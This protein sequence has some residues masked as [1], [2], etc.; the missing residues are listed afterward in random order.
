MIKTIQTRPAI[1]FVVLMGVVSLFADV[2]YE[3]ARSITG[4]YLAVLGA[5]AAVV[6]VV[7]GAGELIGY[8]FRLISG[9]ISDRTGRYWFVTILGY[10][11]NLLAV[12][13]LALT[14]NW[15]LAAILIMSER[16]GKA[17]RTPARD[18]MLSHAV[19]EMGSGWGFGLHEAMDQ[20]GAIL[21]PLVVMLVLFLK[22]SYRDC[23]AVLLI[24]AIVVIFV[25][26][27]A[28][29]LYPHPHD[30]AI[31]ITRFETKNFSKAFWLY[32]LGASLIAAGYADF[33]LIAFHFEKAH[34]VP[35]IWIPVFYTI[36]MGL[37]A[38][39]AL[40]FGKW[41]DD[42]GISV[43]V[44][45]ASLS[46]F[47]A[48]LVFW[49]GFWAAMGGMALWGIGMGAHESVMRAAVSRMTQS[50]KRGTAFGVFNAFYGVSWF[51]GSAAMGICYDRSISFVVLFSMTLQFMAIPLLWTVA[52][53]GRRA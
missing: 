24:P 11:I 15:K 6:G 47:F 31:S 16:M 2:T 42:R 5:N 18:A 52:Q 32:V 13:A 25:L 36:A 37:D 27:A 14:G 7:A 8:G 43:L 21:G 23:F 46:L 20:I 35:A 41:F 40:L 34:S 53:E 39:A 12:P 9:L 1:L 28:R 48:P 45:S 30:L 4:P 29:R 17:I 38:V 51:L 26:F 49:G 33:P 44:L 50:Q 19:E 22:G 10:M 3:G